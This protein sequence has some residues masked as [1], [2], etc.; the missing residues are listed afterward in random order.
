MSLFKNIEKDGVRMYM[1]Y[2]VLIIALVVF[3]IFLT[4]GGFLK[5]NK[6]DDED[7]Y[8]KTL[9]ILGIEE[10][11][12]IIVGDNVDETSFP[13][14]VIRLFPGSLISDSDEMLRIGF[15][16]KDGR[17]YIFTVPLSRIIF[18]KDNDTDPFA[19]FSKFK[20]IHY[21]THSLQD[22]LDDCYDGL[23][24]TLTTNQFNQ[25]IKSN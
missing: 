9:I 25:L 4:S 8:Q 11:C 14:P 19:I 16:A 6:D 22:C 15:D 20:G 13:L 1:L 17:T 23:E 3:T 21:P 7:F 12:R 2:V 5:K 18:T 24:I 10:R